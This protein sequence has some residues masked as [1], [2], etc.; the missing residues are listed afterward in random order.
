MISVTEPTSDKSE[1]EFFPDDW[2]ILLDFPLLDLSVNWRYGK[3]NPLGEDTYD[4]LLVQSFNKNPLHHV[5]FQIWYNFIM[6]L[7]KL[8]CDLTL[9]GYL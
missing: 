3:K 9:S 8:D 2:F 4:Y 7:Q 6:K 5:I 1:K